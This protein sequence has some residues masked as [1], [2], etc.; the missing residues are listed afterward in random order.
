MEYEIN[1]ENAS[2]NNFV[3]IKPSKGCNVID[4]YAT[5]MENNNILGLLPLHRQN[6]EGEV[7]LY[8]KITGKKRLSDTMKRQSFTHDE[9]VKIVTEIFN[10]FENAEKY[11]LRASM[12]NLSLDNIYIDNNLKL[13]FMLIP[14]EDDS[15]MKKNDG[16][17]N[18]FK[19][20]IGQN[21]LKYPNS[22]MQKYANYFFSPVFDLAEFKD[23][24]QDEQINNTKEE[25]I[26]IK[27]IQKGN[28][29]EKKVEV[30]QKSVSEKS[31]ESNF[32]EPK[33]PEPVKKDLSFA[34]PGGSSIKVPTSKESNKKGKPAKV[35]K[36]DKKE[37][38]KEK[39]SLLGS[40]F[41]SKKSDK[42]DNIQSINIPNS[43]Q[44]V[45]AIPQVNKQ[46]EVYANQ[47]DNSWKGTDVYGSDNGTVMYDEDASGTFAYIVHNSKTVKINKDSFTIGRKNADYTINN[48][49]ISGIHITIKNDNGNFFV[50]DENSKN[51]TTINNM[52]ISPYS[53]TQVSNG[54]IIQIGK[55]D[56]LIKIGN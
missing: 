13:Y 42:A 30:V 53:M 55:E 22:N 18:F 21:M 3:V 43:S 56:L 44:Q 23:L 16:I 26:P 24:F 36:D 6:I 4:Y 34:V 29:I 48:S 9:C 50:I 52:R 38:K 17:L 54:D 19:E 33:I 46:V 40:L 37:N 32:V 12:C 8:Y 11:F 2:L 28:N 1:F 7:H 10:I 35:K 14:I 31:N 45:Q 27:V 20:L 41:N 47:Q 5:M 51:G 25:S 15:N 49:I 39:K